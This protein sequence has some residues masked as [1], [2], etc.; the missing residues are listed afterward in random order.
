[1]WRPAAAFYY[2]AFSRRRTGPAVI[3]IQVDAVDEDAKTQLKSRGPGVG[4][5][6]SQ[7]PVLCRLKVS[8]ALLVSVAPG[9]EC[10]L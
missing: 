10:L 6:A 8:R 1:M 2:L 3:K 5:A 9:D 4:A 7:D